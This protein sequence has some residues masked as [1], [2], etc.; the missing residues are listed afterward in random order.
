LRYRSLSVDRVL[1][2]GRPANDMRARKRCD[3]TKQEPRYL[4]S[5]SKEEQLR[6]VARLNQGKKRL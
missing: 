4:K 6:K 5:V 3:G 1:C 2:A